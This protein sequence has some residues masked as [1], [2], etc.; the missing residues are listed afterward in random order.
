MLD[1]STTPTHGATIIAHGDGDGVISAALVA[2]RVAGG[3]DGVKTYWSTPRDLPDLSVPAGSEPV[4]VVDV[5]ADARRPK[6][7]LAFVERL[8]ADGHPVCVIDHHRGWSVERLAE[9]GARTVIDPEALACAQLVPCPAGFDSDRWRTLVTDAVSLDTR[10]PQCELSADGSAIDRAIKY[11]PGD[12]TM[13]D[14]ALRFL[15][16][17]ES[18]RPLLSIEAARY[19][20]VLARTAEVASKFQL[21]GGIAF[22]D[23][24]DVKSRL[25]ISQLSVAGKRLAPVQVILLADGAGK[26]KL[27]ITANR[28]VDLIAALNLTCGSPGRVSLPV[29]QLPRVMSALGAEA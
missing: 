18:L 3:L 21:V 8:V 13:R 10:D 17:D 24:R 25:D 7:A 15:A 27:V 19:D 5:A 26:E 12:N 11:R 29:S 4:Y 6:A 14:L 9:L 22:L 23:A 16:A 1:S 20:A 2:L 28:P